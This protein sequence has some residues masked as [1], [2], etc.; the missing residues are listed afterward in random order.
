M[1]PHLERRFEESS[2]E[3]LPANLS[4]PSPIMS[5]RYHTSDSNLVATA[6]LA[7]S[8]GPAGLSGPAG[9]TG[10]VDQGEGTPID[11]YPITFCPVVF[12]SNVL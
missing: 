8:A 9:P 7:R 3:S 10:P 6:G 4:K 5:S 2:F 11:F 12:V 1:N